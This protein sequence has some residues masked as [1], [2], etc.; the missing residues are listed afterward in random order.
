VRRNVFALA[1][2]WSPVFRFEEASAFSSRIEAAS[3]A[4]KYHLERDVE[5]LVVSA[6]EVH[7]V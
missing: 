4:A 3:F 5:L 6:E 2:G 7:V 1:L